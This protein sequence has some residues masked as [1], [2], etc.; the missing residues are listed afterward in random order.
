[1]CD[2]VPQ[3]FTKHHFKIM[4]GC[5]TNTQLAQ[6]VV[7]FGGRVK[8]VEIRDEFVGKANESGNWKLCFHPND[9]RRFEFSL[10]T[11]VLVHKYL[12]SKKCRIEKKVIFSHAAISLNKNQHAAYTFVTI[13]LHCPW[14]SL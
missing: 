8:G 9:S 5:S 7:L 12:Q 4:K 3:P 2:V 14:R 13:S 10:F 6:L 1:M 11:V